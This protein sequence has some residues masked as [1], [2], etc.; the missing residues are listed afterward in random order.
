MTNFYPFPLPPKS[1]NFTSQIMYF[2]LVHTPRSNRCTDSY[3]EWLK[4]RVSS[5]GRS[6]WGSGRWVTSYGKICPKNS[7]KRGVHRQFQAKAPKFIHRNISGTINPTNK[8][9][10]D[11]VQTIT[12]KQIQNGWPPPSWKSI[13][14]H[15]PAV[16]GPIWMKFGTLMQIYT[17]ITASAKWSRSKPEVKFQYGGRLFFQTENS[18]ILAVN[19]DMSTR[20]GLLINFDLL[21]ALT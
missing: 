4:R 19:G 20:L 15:N 2:F 14:R 11:R 18:N 3:A 12:K 1:P 7:P 13:W 5:Q 8:R 16:H 10:E 17:L 21:K 9:F 6:F